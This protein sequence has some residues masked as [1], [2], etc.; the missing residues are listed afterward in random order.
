ME[1]MPK[2]DMRL[3]DQIC[4]CHDQIC[5][6]TM[7]V[8]VVIGAGERNCREKQKCD[9]YG[10]NL[11]GGVVAGDVGLVPRVVLSVILDGMV[12]QIVTRKATGVILQMIKDDK[13]VDLIVLLAGQPDTRKTAITM[14]MAKSLSLETPFFSTSTMKMLEFLGDSVLDLLIT[15]HLYQSHTYIDPGVLTDLCSASVNNDNFAQ[16]VV[17]HNLHQHLLH[18][19]GLLVSQITKYVKVISESNPKSLPSIIAPKVLDMQTY[20]ARQREYALKGHRHFYFITLNGSEES[21]SSTWGSGLVHF[22]CSQGNTRNHSHPPHHC[23]LLL[24]YLHSNFYNFHNKFHK[25]ET[26]HPHMPH[27][28]PHNH[29]R[30]QSFHNNQET[31]QVSITNKRNDKDDIESKDGSEDE[32]VEGPQTSSVKMVKSIRGNGN[33]YRIGD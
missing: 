12:R 4:K 20:E 16:V 27:I 24:H 30:L 22:H 23:N 11:Y 13:I 14:G 29:R 26:L 25:A 5:Y 17:R 2:L 21:S 1:G 15:W 8:G 10:F 6:L 7:V 28:A 32:G 31:S 18:S 19:S 3:S 9:G 33:L